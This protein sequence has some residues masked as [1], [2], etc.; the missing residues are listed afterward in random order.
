MSDH[1]SLLVGGVEDAYRGSLPSCNIVPRRIGFWL[2]MT[3]VITKAIIPFTHCINAGASRLQIRAA[4]HW[5]DLIHLTTHHP[6]AHEGAQVEVTVSRPLYSP[7]DLDMPQSGALGGG[8]V[9]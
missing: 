7:E 8:R 5:L 1:L 2:L 3:K 4:N 6:F 9:R